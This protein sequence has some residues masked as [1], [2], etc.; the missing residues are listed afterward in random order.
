MTQQV[1]KKNLPKK[2]Q[3]KLQTSVDALN[4]CLQECPNHKLGCVVDCPI[5]KHFKI[6]PHGPNYP[7]PG[8]PKKLVKW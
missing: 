8:E 2:L 7:I 4:Y 1:T 5:R 6:P 3:K